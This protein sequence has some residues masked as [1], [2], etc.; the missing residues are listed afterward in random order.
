MPPPQAIASPLIAPLRGEARK[1]TMS[2][3]SAASTIRPIV[4]L[5]ASRFSISSS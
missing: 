1:A 2:A 5:A 3:T 4:V